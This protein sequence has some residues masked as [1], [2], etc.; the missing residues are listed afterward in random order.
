MIDPESLRRDD[1]VELDVDT[2]AFEGKAIA[3][4]DTFVVF[5]DGALPGDRVRARIVKK[6]KQFAE[7][8]A[9]EVLS[10]SPHRIAPPCPHFGP[11]GG[12][13][14]QHFEYA[15]QQEWKRRHVIDAFERIGAFS[16]LQI[17]ATAPSE[18]IFWYRNKMEFS[19][20]ETRWLLK[21]EM[22]NVERT[23]LFA[24]GLHIPQRYDRILSVEDCRLQSP[25]SNAIL[26]ATRAF[27]LANGER[28][29]TTS[30]HSGNLRHLVIREGKNTGAR[31]VFFL[32]CSESPDMMREYAE[33]LQ[34]PKFG[35][36][37]FVHG[38]STSK[39]NV[40]VAEKEIV[41]FGNGTI[42]E[43]LGS[44][45]FRISP[46]SFFQTNPLQ[47]KALYDIAAE[48]A[49]L[50]PSDT[51]WDFYCGTGS[52]SLYIAGKVKSVLGIEMNP[53]AIENANENAALNGIEN[54][55]FICDDMLKFAKALPES[56]YEAPD[57]IIVD[58]PRPG[59]HASVVEAIGTVAPERLVYISCNPATCARD[60][61]LLAEFGYRIE[62]ITPVDMFPHTYHIECVVKLRK[63]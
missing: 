30:D 20:G 12:C 23:E 56:D 18:S 16:N 49:A 31:M 21:E 35:V 50:K 26:N 29:Y 47:A 59:M 33:L 55:S 40:A 32:S 51:V 22:G 52:I 46:M 62:E 41:Y 13:K 38:I 39:S 10:P 6:K 37:T 9:L 3:R 7:A 1:E 5:I 43:T 53:S 42:E 24:V 27:F 36:T 17:N 34:Q 58:P 57:V 61:A 48:Y 63:N 44:K 14:L 25:E 11:C 15:Q 19:F 8:R 60:C 2:L 54:A 45:R 4:I 28:A